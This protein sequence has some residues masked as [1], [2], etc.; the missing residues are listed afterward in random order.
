MTTTRY[1]SNAEPRT[2]RWCG[3]AHAAQSRA[4]WMAWEGRRGG[5]GT[6]HL[7]ACVLSLPACVHRPDCSPAPNN[8][9]GHGR[10]CFPWR[11][12]NG[13]GQGKAKRSWSN[14]T[15]LSFPAG[16]EIGRRSERFPKYS[17][18]P[19]N[20]LGKEFTGG[21]YLPPSPAHWPQPC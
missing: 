12:M 7:H 18:T 14:W 10:G 4:C 21:G 17:G 8:W 1:C 19:P 5:L 13:G 9:V 16:L 20:Y 3:R 2:V 15:P 6:C 11:G